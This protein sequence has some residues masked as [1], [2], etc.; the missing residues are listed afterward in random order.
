VRRPAQYV[1]GMSR[2]WSLARRYAFDALIVAVAVEGALEVLLRQGA[3]EAPRTTQWFTV[4]ATVLVALPLL[5]RRRFPFAAPAGTWLVAA[6]LS[7]VDGRLIVFTASASVAG[8]AAAFLLGNLRD[9][10]RARLGLAVAVGGAALVAYNEPGHS[11][12][13][14]V[15]TPIL[16]GIG[17]LAGFILRERA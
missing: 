15:F 3:S 12:G 11:A 7:F 9:G 4:P 13:E 2:I 5:A 6:A 17:W 10:T 8:I 1:H 16:F 14:L